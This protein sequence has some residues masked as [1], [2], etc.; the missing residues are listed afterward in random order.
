MTIPE[1][2]Q[3]AWFAALAAVDPEAR[4]LLLALALSGCRR[5]ELR[6]APAAACDS[7]TRLLRLQATRNGKPHTLPVGPYLAELLDAG[8]TGGALFNVSDATV[9]AAYGAAG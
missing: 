8:S 9:R 6:T 5:E 4:R 1:Q 7:E 3:A 2:L